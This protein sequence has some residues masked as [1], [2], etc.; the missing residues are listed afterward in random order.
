MK[1]EPGLGDF[2]TESARTCRIRVT[3]TVDDKQARNDLA[4]RKRWR[5]SCY[6]ANLNIMT[7]IES[8]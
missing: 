3:R 1:I 5:P 7:F 6:P 8:A 4:G 2:A